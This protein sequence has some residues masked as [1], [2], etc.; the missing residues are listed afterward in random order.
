MARP[1]ISART[2]QTIQTLRDRGW[3]TARATQD[4]QI[5]VV[6]YRDGQDP[7]DPQEVVVD[8]PSDKVARWAGDNAGAGETVLP[9]TMRRT[10]TDGFDVEVG[11][12]AQWPG[13][14]GE[15]TRVWEDGGMK[16]AAVITDT[17]TA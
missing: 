4:P 15:V 11:D 14:T 3:A 16:W 5:D 6:I 13:F 9:L 1:L 12:R 7:L 17:G 8:W 10:L 2:V